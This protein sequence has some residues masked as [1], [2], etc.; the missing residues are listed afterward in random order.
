VALSKKEEDSV[1]DLFV[2]STHHLLLFFT[3]QGRVYRAKAY[4]VPLASRTA[5]G[6]PIVNI[7]PVEPGERITAW[8]AVKGYDQGGYL[9]MVTRD[10]M[11]KKTALEEYDTPLR[12]RG[13]IAINLNDDDRLNWVMWTDGRKDLVLATKGGK[14]LRFSET[15]VRPM[16]RQTAG[17]KAI[18]LVDDD[19]LVCTVA[20]DPKDTRDLLTVSEKGLGKRT[21]LEEYRCQGRYTQGVITLSITEKTGAVVGVEVVEDDDEIMC[22]SSGGVLIRVPVKHIRRTGRNAQGVK[23]VTPDPD[24]V[25]RAVAKVVRHAAETGESAE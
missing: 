1:R 15:D 17:V 3:D 22:I 12:T 21:S 9:V 24:T 6:T 23:I 14:A 4:Q 20:V 18:R 19:R 10:G 11:V 25:V 8:L 2:A 16:G 5:R 13:L 7:T